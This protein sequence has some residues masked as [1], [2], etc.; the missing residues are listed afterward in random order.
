MA[1]M[2]KVWAAAGPGMPARPW[3]GLGGPGRP[4]VLLASGL[5]RS[6]MLPARLRALSPAGGLWAPELPHLSASARSPCSTAPGSL[7]LGFR[8]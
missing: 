4:D 3:E 5:P 8:I 7:S 6:H 2:S 1:S